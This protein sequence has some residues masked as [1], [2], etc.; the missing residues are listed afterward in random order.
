MRASDNDWQW[1]LQRVVGVTANGNKW[2]P[3]IAELIFV[4]KKFLH[5]KANKVFHLT[6]QLSV[7]MTEVHTI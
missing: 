5:F 7:F 2:Q 1:V 4:I 3:T 6:D